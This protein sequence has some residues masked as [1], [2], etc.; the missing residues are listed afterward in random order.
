M[1]LLIVEDDRELVAALARGFR[2]E[3]FAVD[4]ALDGRRGLRAAESGA[5]DAVVLDLMLPEI[6]G[7]WVIEALR[8]RGHRVPV[9]FLTARGEVEN[10]VR[11]LRLGGDD[12]LPKPFAFD[13]LVAR[14][15]ALIRRSAGATRNRLAW[16]ELV[17]DADARQVTWKGAPIA[18]TPRELAL[19][20]ALLLHRG[21][22]VSR[23][24]LIRH[25]YEGAFTCDSNVLD[26]H[27]ANLRRKLRRATGSPVVRTVRGAGFLVPE[28]DR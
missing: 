20:E 14:V 12:Y 26:V 22:A 16:R 13:E 23:A 10:R 1:R 18:L 19:L 5:Y 28:P 3:G 27:V 2:Q 21:K 7:F 25:V 11:G 9:L 24:R 17:L 8:Q 4:V 15:R 6:D